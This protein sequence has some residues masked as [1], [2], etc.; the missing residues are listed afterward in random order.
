[1][2]NLEGIIF[3]IISLIFILIELYFGLGVAGG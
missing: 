3:F 2:A 1:M